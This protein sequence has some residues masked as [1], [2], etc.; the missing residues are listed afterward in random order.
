MIDRGSFPES[1][2]AQ[3]DG[4]SKVEALSL[5]RPATNGRP[6]VYVD[7]LAPALQVFVERGTVEDLLT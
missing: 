3:P 5:A 1:G 4:S 6:R 2:V 7:D